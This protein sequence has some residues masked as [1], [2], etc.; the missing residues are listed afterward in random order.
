MLHG[1]AIAGDLDRACR[2]H[3]GIQWRQ[4]GPQEEAA[5]A[6]KH[7]PHAPPRGFA[8][9]QVYHA[10]GIGCNHLGMLAHLHDRSLPCFDGGQ[11]S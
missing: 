8:D 3:A 9:V 7:Q 5:E 2:Y 4:P 11:R 6:G 10:P 1:F